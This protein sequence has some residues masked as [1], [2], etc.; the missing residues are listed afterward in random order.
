MPLISLSWPMT[1]PPYQTRTRREPL[2]RQ[3][4]GGDESVDRSASIDDE[5]TPESALRQVP[6]RQRRR[7]RDRIVRGSHRDDLRATFNHQRWRRVGV[8]SI[9]LVPENGGPRLNGEDGTALDKHLAGEQ[10]R[11]VGAPSGVGDDVAAPNLASDVVGK[12]LVVVEPRQA[13]QP[14]VRVAEGPLEGDVVQKGI[15][16]GADVVHVVEG[17]S[18]ADGPRVEERRV[19][20][21]ISHEH[22]RLGVHVEG[23]ERRLRRAARAIDLHSTA[24]AGEDDVVGRE[25]QHV[26]RCHL[27]DVLREELVVAAVLEESRAPDVGHNE[28]PEYTAS[29]LAQS[30]DG[31]RVVV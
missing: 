26:P 12:Q 23:G 14:Q 2:H 21:W 5:A 7:E 18:P 9:V 22:D 15:A 27:A 24:A 11:F 1:L 6:L 29:S 4:V 10:R 28:I 20:A 3:G 13:G 31:W 19:R 30:K 25:V 17:I 16:D 8:R